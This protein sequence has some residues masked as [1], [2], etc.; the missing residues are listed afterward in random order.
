MMNASGVEPSGDSLGGGGPMPGPWFANTMV[1]TR[2]EWASLNDGSPLNIVRS[3]WDGFSGDVVACVWS[4]DDHDEA[5][6]ARLIAAAPELLEACR[7]MLA[8]SGRRTADK[9]RAAARAAIA[10]VEERP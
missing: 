2:P 8:V 10:K 4:D 9:A 1:M 5:A 3:N 6:T 7:L